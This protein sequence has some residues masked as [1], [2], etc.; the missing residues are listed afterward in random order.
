VRTVQVSEAPDIY[1]HC[2]RT[3]PGGAYP[4][5]VQDPEKRFGCRYCGNKLPEL[6]AESMRTTEVI[7]Q[8]GVTVTLGVVHFEP[9]AKVVPKCEG[10]GE[11]APDDTSPAG[12][13]WCGRCPRWWFG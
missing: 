4:S 3:A 7:E 5:S 2:G 11:L 1:C 8:D 6:R 13:P 9:K 10:C 12:A